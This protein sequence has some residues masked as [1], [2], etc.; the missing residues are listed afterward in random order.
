MTDTAPALY[1]M[2]MGD[3]AFLAFHDGYVARDLPAGFIRNASD[4]ETAQAMQEAG[5]PAGKLVLSFTVFALEQGGRL[6]LFDAG[7]GENGPPTAGRLAAALAAGGY[8]PADVDRVLVSHFHGDHILG[9]IRRD[10]TPSYPDAK[11]LVPTPERD[12]WMDDARMAAAPDG[13]RPTF[14]AARRVLGALGTRVGTFGWGDEPVPGVRALQLDGHT[15]GMTGF[16]ITAGG[17][18]VLYVADVSNTPAV[19]ARHPDWQAGFDIDGPRATETRTR[20][21]AEAAA[22]H[23]RLAFYHAPFPAI[24]TLAPVGDRYAWCPRIWGAEG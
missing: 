8:A 19:F 6:T 14:E 5:M 15:P 10:G 16:D 1:R 24:G 22:G 18:R 21:F 20:L 17:E 4:A 2:P 9:L 11:V 7:F 13:L 3:S 12:F 23:W